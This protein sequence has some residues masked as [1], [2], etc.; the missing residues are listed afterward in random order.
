MAL[1]A[2]TLATGLKSLGEPADEAATIVAISTA[3][4]SYWEESVANAVAANP[5]PAA[6]VAAF[7]GAMVGISGTG[8]T[9]TDAANKFLAACKSFWTAATPVLAYATV[10]PPAPS[11]ITFPPFMLTPAAEAAWVAA[12]AAVFTA[13]TANSLSADASADAIAA[14]IHSGQAGA[15]FVDTTAPTPIPYV[16]A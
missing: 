12:L 14:A 10:P 3:W 8:N 4:Q 13:N 15:A 5:S 6:A 2:A 16:V 7:E 1:S 11:Y 9:V